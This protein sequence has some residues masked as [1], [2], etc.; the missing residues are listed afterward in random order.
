MAIIDTCQKCGDTQ[1]RHR[2]YEP[3]R[4]VQS[5][6]YFNAPEQRVLCPTCARNMPEDAG[7]DVGSTESGIS[8]SENP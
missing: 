6:S 2:G 1:K 3:F 8:T 4:V 7:E 5:T